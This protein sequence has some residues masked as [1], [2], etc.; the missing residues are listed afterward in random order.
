MTDALDV[1]SVRADETSVLADDLVRRVQALERFLAA[2]DGHLPDARLAAA[3]TVVERAGQRLALSRGHSVVALAGS[4]GS[5]KSSLFNALARMDLSPVGVRRP[6]TGDT[7]ACVW[8]AA[9]AAALLDWL[10]VLPRHRFV[11]ESELDGQA[12]SALRGL[13]LLD[14]PDV[15]SID[16]AHRAEV[17]RILRLVDLVVW[18]VDP[19]KYADKLIHSYLRQYQRHRDVTVVVLNQADR[20]S[21]SEVGQCLADLRRLLDNDGLTGVPALAVSAYGSPGCDELRGVLE[22]AVAARQAA[23]LRL[24]GDIDGVTADLSTMVSLWVAGP[25]LDQDTL[26]ALDNALAAAAGVPAVA[27][28]TEYAYRRR[29]AGYLGWPVLHRRR[30]ESP[31]A[32]DEAAEPAEPRPDKTRPEGTPPH[33]RRP[34]GTRPARPSAEPTSAQRAALGPAVRAVADQPAGALPAPWPA[35]LRAAAGA[36]LDD[37]P[38]AL[39][40]AVARTDLG[41]SRTPWWWRVVAG[42]QWLTVLA[43]AAGLVWLLV[44]YG[45]R[46]LGLLSSAYPAL[47]AVPLPALLA[48]GGAVLGPALAAAT[49]PLAAAAARRARLRAES[50]LRGAV[51]EVS[52]EYVVAPVRAVLTAYEQA[53]TALADAG[54]AR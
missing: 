37:L 40:R 18:V 50:R 9:D 29:A 12:E 6:T 5:G 21:P 10:G 51:A 33:G 36:H 43:A 47:G 8:G 44:G 14:L 31:A 41:L 28:L 34:D 32:R 11:R 39:D 54:R 27:Q 53:R 23:L 24:S 17:D 42:V 30:R 20:L 3:H 26:R 38:A 1:T 22:R 15:D 48:V 46:A 52:R 25:A 16:A 19:Q 35:V 13:V 45:G 7:Y 49:R 2:V 4:T